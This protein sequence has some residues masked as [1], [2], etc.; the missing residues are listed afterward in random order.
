MNV[1]AYRFRT[2]YLLGPDGWA[3]ALAMTNLRALC[4]RCVLPDA[5]A[6]PQ[7][8]C[9]VHYAQALRELHELG[10]PTLERT[11]EV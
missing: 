4:K 10:H 8:S 7:A 11:T 3:P 2:L 9:V 6:F 1:D 5:A